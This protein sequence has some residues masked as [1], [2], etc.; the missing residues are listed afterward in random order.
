MERNYS[1]GLR[2]RHPIEIKYI[3]RYLAK[4]GIFVPKEITKGGI[5]LA[6]E[7]T[8]GK[9]AL[10]WPSEFYLGFSGSLEEAHILNSIKSTI[11]TASGLKKIKFGPNLLTLSL[12]PFDGEEQFKREFSQIA[13]NL[14][15]RLYLGGDVWYTESSDDFNLF[16]G[17]KKAMDVYTGGVQN[18][19]I[20]KIE[21]ES[22]SK[23]VLTLD[24]LLNRIIQH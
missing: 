10:F 7:T 11:E 6:I 3:E 5:T 20:K 24:E 2:Y 18:K 4:S 12:G 16:L 9:L 22:T 17:T 1:V 14:Q 21:F 13:K 8:N 23:P 19:D 15:E